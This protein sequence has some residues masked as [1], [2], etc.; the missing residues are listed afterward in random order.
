MPHRN[1][2]YRACS[3][4]GDFSSQHHSSQPAISK[5]FLIFGFIFGAAGA[6]A[7]PNHLK[8]QGI[9]PTAQHIDVSGA[10]AFVAPGLSDMRGP[11]PA[12]NAV[13][14]HGNV[15][16]NG[17]TGFQ[18]SIGAITKIYGIGAYLP[19]QICLPQHLIERYSS[20]QELTW[21]LS[22]RHLAR[23]RWAMAITFLFVV[24]QGK[25]FLL[26]EGYLASHE[27]SRMLIIASR[28]MRVPQEEICTV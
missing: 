18:K 20:N 19:S 5:M 8:R 12:M 28:G 16:R 3:P 15:A 21:Q 26:W 6:N 14:N 13:A 23:Y 27:Q 7:F 9:D 2:T 22:L 11:C 17:Y 24:H 4:V 10:H 1:G 25:A